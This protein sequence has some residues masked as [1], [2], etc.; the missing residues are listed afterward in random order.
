MKSDATYI[1]IGGT[2]G[3]GRSIS[4]WMIKKGARNIVLLS[5][6]GSTAGKV[7]ELIEEAKTQ[8]V[9]VAVQSCDVYDREQVSKLFAEGI[10]NMPPVK[11]IIHAAMVL[12]VSI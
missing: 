1:I 10:C 11:G 6:S 8:D 5:R 7:G 3:L 4:R 2:G 9:H 12:R